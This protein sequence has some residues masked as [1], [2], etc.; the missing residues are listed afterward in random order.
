MNETQTQETQKVES[1][2]V[3][4]TPRMEICLNEN[5]K[6]F[7]KT[8][9]TFDN[10]VFSNGTK[11]DV[12]GMIAGIKT[13]ASLCETDRES[14]T[15]ENKFKKLRQLLEKTGIKVRIDSEYPVS[16]TRDEK[17]NL[18][19][20]FFVRS[21]I[22]YK[23]EEVAQRD[24]ILTDKANKTEEDEKKIGRLLG[25]PDTST[26][27][28]LNKTERIK[29]EEAF[30]LLG[31]IDF[32]PLFQQLVMSRKNFREE[33]DL[34]GRIIMETMKKYMPKSYIEYLKGH[35]FPEEYIKMVH[36][37]LEPA[38]EK[39]YIHWVQRFTI[40]PIEE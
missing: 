26:E 13:T 25:Y 12:V 35:G 20:S 33:I 4:R 38:G 8:L 29:T 5:Q 30:D 31:Q 14:I 6:E 24:Q 27:A 16:Y 23:S 18:Q 2:D 17:G 40:T 22:L 21:A 3:I 1:R 34:Y 32:A 15:S 7:L 36:N 9:D 11:V 19:P 39:K 37:G 10:S 28:F